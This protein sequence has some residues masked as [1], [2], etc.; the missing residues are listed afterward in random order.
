MNLALALPS[1]SGRKT[2]LR[3]ADFPPAG[4]QLSLGQAWSLPAR[5]Q[6]PGK[7]E[8]LFWLSVGPQLPALQTTPPALPVSIKLP[9]EAALASSRGRL[10]EINPCGLEGRYCN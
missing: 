10:R 7:T 2:L 8:F 5:H 9:W 6:A 1:T 4:P 3:P